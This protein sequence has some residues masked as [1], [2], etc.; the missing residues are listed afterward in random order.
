M[1]K[2]LHYSPEFAESDDFRLAK[3]RLWQ[4][5]I[6]TCPLRFTANDSPYCPDLEE[7]ACAGDVDVEEIYFDVYFPN[8]D[9]ARIYLDVVITDK[10]TRI[11]PETKPASLYCQER[12][13]QVALYQLTPKDRLAILQVILG[14]CIDDFEDHEPAKHAVIA[15]Q[16]CYSLHVQDVC[17][18][19]IT[20]KLPDDRLY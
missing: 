8:N 14:K 3:Q 2:E 9:V 11:H 16:N 20:S 15:L 13:M 5:M 18:D 1:D 17:D 19:R 12:E 4:L 6:T 7:R 10:R